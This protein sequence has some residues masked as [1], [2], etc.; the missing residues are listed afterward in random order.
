MLPEQGLEDHGRA[1]MID[2]VVKTTGLVPADP[3]LR[4]PSGCQKRRAVRIAFTLAGCDYQALSRLPSTSGIDMRDIHNRM[5]ETVERRFGLVPRA[6][7]AWA[8]RHPMLQGGV[9]NDRR[10]SFSRRVHSRTI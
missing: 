10:N 7:I 4:R 6:D 8:W 3:N 5:I 2:L 1:A 9:Q